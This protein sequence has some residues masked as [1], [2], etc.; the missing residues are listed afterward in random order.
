MVKVQIILGSTRENRA[1]W[2]IANWVYEQAKLRKDM[3][4]ELVD[5]KAWPL[6]FY[7]EA[8]PVPMLKGKYK[9]P[10]AKKWS[11]KIS[12]AD[13]YIIVTPEYNHGYPA[14]LKN[15]LDYLYFEW[16]KKPVSF[17][18]Y[19]GFVGGSRAVEQLRQVVIELQMAP[20][21]QA[22]HFIHVYKMTDE[23]LQHEDNNKQAQGMFDQLVWWAEAL[24]A[25]REKK[26]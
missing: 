6:P 17:V 10:L 21:R 3:E 25:A 12:G 20:M 5:L 2:R 4:A 9:E 18:S 1:G 23:E 24:K 16:S 26:E 13:G 15:A 14:V 22:V 7:D 19:G 8:A 11:E